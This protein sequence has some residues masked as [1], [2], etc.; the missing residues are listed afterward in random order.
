MT[1]EELFEEYRRSLGLALKRHDE[2]LQ[3]LS[4]TPYRDR[5]PLYYKIG[6]YEGIIEDLEVAL[7]ALR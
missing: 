1:R 5:I 2:L 3:E 4:I 7:L 6:V